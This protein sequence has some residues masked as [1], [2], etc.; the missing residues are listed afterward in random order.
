MN[1]VIRK[2][3]TEDINAIYRIELEGQA[4]WSRN[5]FADELE[6]RF[7][8]FPV[9]ERDGAIIGFAV[10][11]NVADEIQLNNIGIKKEN[12]RRGLGT[13]M[14]NH[15]IASPRAVPPKKIYLEVGVDNGPAL[16]FY[17]KSGFIEAGRRKNY[18]DSID[19]ILMERELRA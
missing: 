2:A 16:S 13:V 10:A 19:A 18:Y 15:I 17:R 11:W 4:R 6:L 12:R 9:M 3:T 7:S 14:L 8:N 1:P 5:Q